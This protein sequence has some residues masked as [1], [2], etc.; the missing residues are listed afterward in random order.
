M[1][2]ARP[3]SR[4]LNLRPPRDK[5]DPMSSI[6]RTIAAPGSGA[7]DSPAGPGKGLRGGQI[8]L[9][10][11]VVIG[12]STIA[13]AYV[14][15]S[16]VGPTAEAVGNHL[17][18]IFI[19]GF[20]PMFLV[21]LGYRELNAAMPDNGTT[22]TWT[23]KAFGPRAG[24]MGGWAML[25]A[26]IIVISNLAGVAVDFLYLCLAQ[27]DGPAGNRRTRG[28]PAGQHRHLPGARGG[29]RV[30]VLPRAAHHARRAVGAGAPAGPGAG[31]VLRPPPSARRAAS[32]APPRSAGIGSTP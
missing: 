2:R 31:V 23:W 11:A 14:L 10:A 1:A 21:A 15:T 30:G 5:G 24:W 28:G 17:P 18:A 4:T 16:S 25:A 12:V 8:G 20:I 27:A 7:A 32:P 13:P 19:V 29:G 9:A 6:Q 22:F 26:N 3:A